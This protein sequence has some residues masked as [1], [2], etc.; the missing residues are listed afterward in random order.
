MDYGLFDIFETLEQ[1]GGPD[2]LFFGLFLDIRIDGVLEAV[3]KMYKP[4][5]MLPKIIC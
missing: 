3:S 4:S 5:D 2:D 1:L